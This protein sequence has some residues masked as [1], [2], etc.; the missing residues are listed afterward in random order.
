MAHF[1][2]SN[3]LNFG[4][5]SGTG[6]WVPE[7]FSQKAQIVFRKTSVAMALTNTMYFGEITKFGDTVNVIK[8]P[9]ITVSSYLRGDTVTPQALADDQFVLVIDQANKFAFSEDDVEERF[10]HIDW[11]SL[12]TNQAAYRLAD[13]FDIS[14]LNYLASDEA[15]LA[16]NRVNDTVEAN[17]LDLSNADDLLNAISNMGTRLSLQNVPHEDRWLLLPYEGLEVLAKAD[18]KL[19]NMD[20]NGGATNLMNGQYMNGMLRGFN[21]YVSNNV[22]TYTSTGSGGTADGRFVMLAGHKS[23]V[24]TAQ[25][26]NKIETYRDQTT[27]RDVVRGLHVFGRRVVR[28]ESTVRAYVKFA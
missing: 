20:Y 10:T 23:G 1:S 4:G 2:G 12:A 8:E 22:P 7:I 11:T 16:A 18:S 27:F 6:N 28:S 26:I 3:T 25:S 21:L 9:Q 17:T 15:V 14:V 24:A 19:L 13:A 5:A